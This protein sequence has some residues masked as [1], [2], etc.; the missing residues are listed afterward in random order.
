MNL[1]EKSGLDIRSQ[2]EYISKNI[3]DKSISG[4]LIT[5]LKN[6]LADLQSIEYIEVDSIHFAIDKRESGDTCKY[7]IWCKQDADDLKYDVEV[8]TSYNLA[9]ITCDLC[10]KKIAKYISQRIQY[11]RRKT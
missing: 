2:I 9:N 6:I 5:K 10:K 1:L 11:E 4:P 3:K 8:K 7:A